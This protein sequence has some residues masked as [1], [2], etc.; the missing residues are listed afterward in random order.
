MLKI[1]LRFNQ[2]DIS[3]FQ[4]MLIRN[5]QIINLELYLKNKDRLNNLDDRITPYINMHVV[6]YDSSNL[7]ILSSNFSL[8]FHW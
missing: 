3:K 5:S 8:Q 6:M 7:N 4:I 2:R 1:Q